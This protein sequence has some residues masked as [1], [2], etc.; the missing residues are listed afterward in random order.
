MDDD[1][2]TEFAQNPKICKAIHMPL[3]S[4]S[5]EILRKMKRGYSKEWFLNTEIGQDSYFVKTT[6]FEV[7]KEHLSKI[8]GALVEYYISEDSLQFIRYPMVMF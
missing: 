3:Q 6:E 5:S 4:G 2:I 8:Y 1:F 7:K